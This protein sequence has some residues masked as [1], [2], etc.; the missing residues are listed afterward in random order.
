MASNGLMHYSSK[1]PCQWC[2][3]GRL[4]VFPNMR[5][6]DVSKGATWNATLLST[7][8]WRASYSFLFYML[9]LGYITHLNMEPDE[10]HIM[11]WGTSMYMLGSIM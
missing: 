4:Q 6:N 3:R 8:E 5:F 10:L 1:L 2:V 7:H 11:H 9:E